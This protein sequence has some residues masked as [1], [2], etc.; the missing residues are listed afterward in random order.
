MSN[1]TISKLASALK[2]SSDKLISQLNDAGI[3]VKDENE[4]ISNDEKLML[5]NHLRGSHGT[6]KEIKSPKKLTVNRRSQSELKLSGGFGTSRTVNVEVRK[7]K[8]YLN[9]ESLIEEA[10]QED[11]LK[12]QEKLENEK[13]LEA[14][15]I[16]ETLKTDNEVQDKTKDTSMPIADAPPTPEKHTKASKKKRK[17][18]KSNKKEDPFEIE[19]LHV[20]GRVKRKKKRQIRRTV[21]PASLDQ[22]HLFE[23][24]TTNVRQNY[25]DIM[26][27][28]AISMTSNDVPRFSPQG[29][30]P[31]NGNLGEGELSMNE[32]TN[33]LNNK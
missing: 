9:K 10:K 5:L 25:S 13:T 23:K 26:N 7:K 11:L 12:E 32:I 4:E 21:N 33:L 18:P 31:V 3:S 19:E 6:K 8:T 28:T 14:E 22:S 1:T 16:E 15:Q 27:E 24:P 17:K 20:K 2:I 30:D 29:V